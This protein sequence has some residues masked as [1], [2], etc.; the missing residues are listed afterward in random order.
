MQ[1][2]F[3]PKQVGAM[4]FRALRSLNFGLPHDLRG[5]VVRA[6]PFLPD[7]TPLKHR[8]LLD[9]D[10][11]PS[12]KGR[13]ALIEGYLA[14]GAPTRFNLMPSGEE[15]GVITLQEKASRAFAAGAIGI[16]FANSED[17]L[18]QPRIAVRMPEYAR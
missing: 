5:L 6:L 1:S 12:L 18:Y 7:D 4:K 3:T 14:Q 13:I 8:K 2:N 15:R 9:Q 17:K 16:V 10:N 11:G